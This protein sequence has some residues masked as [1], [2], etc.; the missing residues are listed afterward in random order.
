MCEG[1]KQQITL[2]DQTGLELR[3]QAEMIL[4]D[5]SAYRGK[6]KVKVPAAS[7]MVKQLDEYF[8]LRTQLLKLYGK[9]AEQSPGPKG[10]PKP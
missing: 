1:L 10:T 4:K 6:A 3:T 8:G 5:L 2:L 7:G 9:A